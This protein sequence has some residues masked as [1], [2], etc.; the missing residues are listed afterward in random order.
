MIDTAYPAVAEK[1][2][3]AAGHR[4]NELDFAELQTSIAAM[5]ANTGAADN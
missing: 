4:R 1:F 3:R 5:L 2:C